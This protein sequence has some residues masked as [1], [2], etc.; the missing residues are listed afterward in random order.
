MNT[1]STSIERAFDQVAIDMSALEDILTGGNTSSQ[2][3]TAI[4][5][6]NPVTLLPPDP[7]TPLPASLQNTYPD[8]PLKSSTPVDLALLCHDLNSFDLALTDLADLHTDNQLNTAIVISLF[9]DRYDPETNNGGYWGDESKDADFLMGSRLWLLQQS[10][11]T[12]DTLRTAEDYA[13]ESLQW[14]IDDGLVIQ[15]DVSASWLYDNK[16]HQLN[17]SVAVKPDPEGIYGK[18]HYQHNFLVARA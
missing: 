7:A 8:N 11:V 12:T 14:L 6:V 5:P 3:I 4:Y 1:F 15:I 13:N 17:L 10:K 2:N 18:A 9:T 16:K